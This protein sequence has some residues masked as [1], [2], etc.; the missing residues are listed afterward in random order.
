MTAGLVLILVVAVAYLATHLAFDWIARRFLIVSGAEYLLLG[1]LLGPQVSGVLSAE[2]VASFAPLTTLALGWI[3]AIVGVQFAIPALVQIRSQTYKLAL[4]QSLLTVAFVAGLEVLALAWLFGV[5]YSVAVPPGLALGAIAA[6][7]SPS[8]IE[9][10]SRRLGR[11]GPVVR[12]LQVATSIDALV[13]V[14][15]LG[16]LICLVH[17]VSPGL[18]RQLTATEWAAVSIGIGAVGGLLFHLFLGTERERDRLF[19]ALAGALILVSGAAAYLGLSPLLASLVM[20][21]TLANTSENRERIAMTLYGAE[22]P[23]YFVLL[24]FAGASWRPS[25]QG[26]WWLP[27]VLFLAARYVGKV[28]GA[29]LAARMSG[30]LEELGPN[31]GRALIGQ[32]GLALAL[33]LD[34]LPHASALAPNIVFSAAVASVLLTDLSAARI[35]RSVVLPFVP[36]AERLARQV[37]GEGEGEGEENGTNGTNGSSAPGATEPTIGGAAGATGP[38]PPA[39]G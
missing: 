9:V 21:A 6:A 22:R 33:G 23:F 27:V 24:V 7:S 14:L 16:L 37:E 35:V 26:W 32:G 36:G 17:P 11:R 29:R 4:L 13:S 1:I 3:G 30:S 38:V 10:A 18:D 19:I 25:L 39:G 31:W 15:V 5:P 2:A 28:G 8:A 34:Y 12:L 20:A